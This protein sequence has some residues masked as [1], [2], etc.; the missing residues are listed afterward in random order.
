[1]EDRP[2]AVVTGGSKRIGAEIAR[3]LNDR[4][5][6]VYITSRRGLDDLGWVPEWARLL[7]GDPGREEDARRLVEEV[8]ERSGRM[9]VL[10]ANASSYHVG[11]LME[12]EGGEF[13]EAIEGCIYPVHF[14]AREALPLMKG[15]GRASLIILGLA[16]SC[17][18]RAYS[19][20][21]AH[22]AA[23]AAVTVLARSMAKELEGTGISVSMVSPGML[24]PND[25]SA[26][27]RVADSVMGAISREGLEFV[28]F[29]VD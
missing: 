24:D 5:Y 16:G 23:K 14:M 8:R 22:A 10:V 1:M 20:I 25:R 15:S 4:G 13:R 26:M 27:V 29:D 9:D 6:I 21:A 7:K 19:K 18:A 28:E 3:A 12:M 17:N 11:P 2:V